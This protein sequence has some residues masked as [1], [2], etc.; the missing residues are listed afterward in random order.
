M[1]TKYKKGKL[2]FVDDPKRLRLENYFTDAAL[3]EEPP[4]EIHWPI[5]DPIGMLLNDKRGD[6]AIAGPLHQIMV[7]KQTN[8]FTW[9]ASDNDALE[10]YEGA[11]GFDPSKDD[12]YGNNPTDGGCNLSD[13]MDYWYNTGFGGH[14]IGPSALVNFRDIK[15]LKRAIHIFGGVIVG[16]ALPKS[17]N[18][19]DQLWTAPPNSIG[20]NFPG[21]GGGHCTILTGYDQN[22]IFDN[23]TWG[24][25]RYAD[26]S[27]V[28]Y[29]MDECHVAFSPEWL[30]DPTKAPNSIDLTTLIQDLKLLNA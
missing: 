4:L 1:I 14:K 29:C 12:A 8:G 16:W 19:D 3:L 7:W 28:P 18:D 30:M 22:N 10:G 20:D 5:P 26:W 23:I 6:C 2:P 25:K 15:M 11:G 27:Y 13:V 21:S 24:S 17:L 9:Y